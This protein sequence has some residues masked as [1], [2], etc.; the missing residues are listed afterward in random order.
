GSG[1][2]QALKDAVTK[3]LAYEVTSNHFS[4]SMANNNTKIERTLD[5][6]N[7]VV[8]N[9]VNPDL[10]AYYP[11]TLHSLAYIGGFDH[12]NFMQTFQPH[13]LDEQL[14]TSNL[15][16]G[17]LVQVTNPALD[18]ILDSSHFQYLVYSGRTN[19]YSITQLPGATD[20]HVSYYNDVSSGNIL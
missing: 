2:T 1:T 3:A 17:S 19:T 4:V 6:S 15:I 13:P 11:L 18:P 12:F 9:V 16:N 5:L 10:T 14:Y 20:S 7:L 8:K